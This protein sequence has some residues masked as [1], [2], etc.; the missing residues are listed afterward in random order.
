MTELNHAGKIISK[1]LRQLPF[2]KGSS[3]STWQ[4]VIDQRAEGKRDGYFS[5]LRAVGN[6]VKEYIAALPEERQRAMWKETGDCKM[7]P[8]PPD[9]E[10]LTK[11][12]YPW[13]CR[14]VDKPIHRAVRR[15]LDMI[16]EET[17]KPSEATLKMEE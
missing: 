17:N 6:V 5:S 3:T 13:V 15:R 1:R 4:A 11:L 10:N 16:Y 7:F 9:A 12:L 8:K 14:A 2:R